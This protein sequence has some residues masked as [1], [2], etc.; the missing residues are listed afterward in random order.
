MLLQGRAEE[1]RRLFE[2][3][4][5]LYEAAGDRGGVARALNNL[6]S[7]VSDGPDPRRIDALYEEGL[8]IARAIGEQGQVARFLISNQIVNRFA[9]AR[10]L[11][12]L[13]VL[14]VLTSQPPSLKKK[15]SFKEE[16]EYTTITAEI[17]TLVMS[18]K[19]LKIN[20]QIRETYR[21]QSSQSSV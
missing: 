12:V 4:K 6:A 9:S 20:S 10:F 3:A 21:T 14:R 11:T 7:A 1:A 13:G 17:E 2:N 18:I 16:K 8:A 5:A 19:F 15:L